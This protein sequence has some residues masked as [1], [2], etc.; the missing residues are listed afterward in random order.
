MDES[1]TS[2]LEHTHATQARNT[3]PLPN[4]PW[5][6]P[7]AAPV[8]DVCGVS[9][10]GLNETVPKGTQAGDLGSKLPS[11][12]P[13]VWV[14]GST[15]EV[16]WA[17]AI[18]H[19]GGYQYRLCPADQPLTEECMQRSPLTFASK[20]QKLRFQNGTELSFTGTFTSDGT[21]PQGSVWARSPLPLAKP[22][23]HCSPDAPEHDKP[24]EPNF[25]FC[26]PGFVIS[27]P[28][29]PV[30]E[31][32][33]GPGSLGPYKS[34]AEN[35]CFGFFNL[36]VEIVDRL[37][38]PASLAPGRYVLGWRWDCQDTYEVWSHCADIRIESAISLAV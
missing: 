28:E 24:G 31:G 23:Y 25:P 13:T 15:V 7:G 5:S 16:A 20:T 6:A 11:T 26:P 12:K 10:G 19:Q 21:Y 37:S 9:G 17:V 32:C 27:E 14:A 34:M 38:I 29:F 8:L 3:P 22:D 2:H 4:A 36:R 35:G 30:P 33:S 1:V 18:N